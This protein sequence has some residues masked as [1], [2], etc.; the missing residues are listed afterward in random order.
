MAGGLE[1][2]HV[3]LVQAGRLVRMPGAVVEIPMLAVFHTGQDVGD[4]AHLHKPSHI[5]GTHTAQPRT[6][7]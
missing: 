6:S 2:P 4:L 1:S 3:P 5:S 7:G